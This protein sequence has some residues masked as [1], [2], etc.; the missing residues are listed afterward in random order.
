MG[1]ALAG[2][3]LLSQLFVVLSLEP[4]ALC[5]LNRQRTTELRSPSPPTPSSLSFVPTFIEHLL[6][7]SPNS[8][9]DEVLTKIGMVSTSTKLVVPGSE[10]YVK[11]GVI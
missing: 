8:S 5:I 9:G 4:K 2:S 3:L 7:A 11:R 1:T 6:L 10:V